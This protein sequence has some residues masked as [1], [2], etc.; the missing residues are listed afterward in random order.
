[1]SNICG[2]FL[3]HFQSSTTFFRAN[4]KCWYWFL[5]TDDWAEEA[6]AAYWSPWPRP[7]H[8]HQPP[9][10]CLKVNVVNCHH[11]HRHLQCLCR[12]CIKVFT[13]A[14]APIL[15]KKEKKGLVS[16]VPLGV[17]LKCK[18]TWESIFFC[19]RKKRRNWRRSL[20]WSRR[21]ARRSYT[22]CL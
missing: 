19:S 5:L 4:Q 3:V 11:H 17:S 13:S 12:L 16:Y 7:P 9:A 14:D 8:E 18:A 15:K 6:E 1:M 21:W 2:F 10:A 20:R 22:K